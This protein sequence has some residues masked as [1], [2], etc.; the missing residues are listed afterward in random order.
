MTAKNANPNGQQRNVVVQQSARRQAA[1]M[2]REKELAKEKRRVR[3]ITDSYQDARESK[4]V[5]Q[6]EKGLGERVTGITPSAKQME[7]KAASYVAG[8]AKNGGLP[9]DREGR[10]LQRELTPER[11]EMNQNSLEKADD[12]VKEQFSH[13]VHIV[14]DKVH[15]GAAFVKDKARQGIHTAN[16]VVKQGAA[17]VVDKTA[18][19][20]KGAV[21]TVTQE[22]KQTAN[23]VIDGV[24]DTVKPKT[25]RRMPNVKVKSK[26]ELQREEQEFIDNAPRSIRKYM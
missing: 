15:D 11:A 16:D 13:G 12:F 6:V 25:E 2:E 17:T 22:T 4:N 9:N 14:K 5:P 8:V 26:A 7:R 23:G 18:D 1:R 3:E 20:A 10:Q 21:N 19:T 24:R